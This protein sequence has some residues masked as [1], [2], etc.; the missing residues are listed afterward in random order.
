MVNKWGELFW[1]CRLIEHWMIGGWIEQDIDSWM[2]N[3]GIKLVIGIRLDGKRT[4]QSIIELKE[5]KDG[6]ERDC[7][8][9]RSE[10]VE[11]LV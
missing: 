6:W 5:K 10:L 1:G 2:F 9:T 11:Y 7:I 3:D 4:S 8:R